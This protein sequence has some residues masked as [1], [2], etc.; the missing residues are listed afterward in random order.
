M[1]FCEGEQEL[2]ESLHR[3]FHVPFVVPSHLVGF[4][5]ADGKEANPVF[6]LCLSQVIDVHADGGSDLWV[7]PRGLPVREKDNGQAV[8][9]NLYA[10]E[11]GSVGDDIGFSSMFDHRDPIRS[12]CGVIVYSDEVKA[13]IPRLEK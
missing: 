6:W 8:A 3:A 5:D 9:R 1:V 10:S 7:S 13:S 2:R 11:I 4:G 12:D